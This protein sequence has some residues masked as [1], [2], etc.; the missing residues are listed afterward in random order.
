MN[1]PLS[2]KVVMETYQNGWGRPQALIFGRGYQEYKPKANQNLQEIMEFIDDVLAILPPEK[3][4]LA[5][6]IGLETGG[7][8]LIWRQ[9]FARVMSIEINL[10][11]SLLFVSG[12]MN[13]DS[14]R[15]VCSNSM[16]PATRTIVEKELNSLKVDLLFVDGDH[17]QAGVESDYLNYEPFVA[18]GGIVAFHDE[19]FPVFFL[20]QQSFQFFFKP[21]IH[22]SVNFPFLICFNPP[23][24]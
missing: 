14:S 6:E 4:K 10:H 13:S 21:V 3:R 23:E 24:P 17:S 8:H 2:S 20:K 18:S 11:S 15:V 16:L 7:T 9:L 1:E 5:L 22:Y 12:L 19:H